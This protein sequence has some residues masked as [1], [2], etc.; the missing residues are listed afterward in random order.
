MNFFEYLKHSVPDI[1]I[2]PNS[3]SHYF[4]TETE[5][6]VACFE[7]S[8]IRVKNINHRDLSALLKVPTNLIFQYISAIEFYLNYLYE[9]KTDTFNVNLSVNNYKPSFI[10]SDRLP[11]LPGEKVRKRTLIVP[12]YINYRNG[13]KIFFDAGGY[14]TIP[15]I[16]Q[17]KI[18]EEEMIHV[19]LSRCS[20]YDILNFFN[21]KTDK[22]MDIP[23]EIHTSSNILEASYHIVK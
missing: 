12:S 20:Y 1:R 10:D 7:G 13:Y 23:N 9:I 3:H 17:I 21:K 4:K 14:P 18:R 15:A 11:S 8:C 16:R 6:P 2:T 19:N 5:H 22:F